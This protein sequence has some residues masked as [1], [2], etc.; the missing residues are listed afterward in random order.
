MIRKTEP[1]YI[2]TILY[3]IIIALTYVLIRVAIVDPKDVV[4]TAKYN[5]AEARARLLN[6]REGQILWEKQNG[7]FTDDLNALV[8]FIKNDT[9][10]AKVVAGFDSV[11]QQS[12]NPFEVLGHGEFTPE[13]LLTSPY[14]GNP[15][16]VKVDTTIDVDTVMNRRGKIIRIDS[17]VTIGKRYEIT[18]PDNKDK[19]GDVYSDA[20]KNTASWE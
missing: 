14:S 8:E 9:M 5:R 3:V 2:H 13:S 6:L 17:T 12:T 1:W 10:V 16:V 20:L 18:C 19:I 4:E 11:A 15:F 7:Q